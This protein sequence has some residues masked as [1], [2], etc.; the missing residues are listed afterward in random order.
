MRALELLEPADLSRRGDMDRR[1]A[2]P[3]Q[4]PL[5]HGLPPPRQ[6]ERVN[7][8]RRGDRLH[9]HATL[10]T[11]AHSGEL[12]LRTVFLNLLRTGSWH[13][14]LPLVRWK[15]LQ[16]RGRFPRQLQALVRPL[17]VRLSM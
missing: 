17:P 11:Q 14:H 5:T 7:V 2:L 8:E 1:S 9:L 4:T 6:H 15:C 12:E 16:N 10:S 13:R 3:S